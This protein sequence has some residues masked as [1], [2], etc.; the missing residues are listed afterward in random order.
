V[1]LVSL[2]AVVSVGTMILRGSGQVE[3][4]LAEPMLIGIL[5]SCF[6]L[7]IVLRSHARNSTA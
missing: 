3:H 2:P 7:L 5:V 4:V 1:L 6:I